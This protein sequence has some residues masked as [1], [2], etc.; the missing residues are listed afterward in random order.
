MISVLR[1]GH[2][3]FRDKRIT[4][5]VALVARAFTA[6]EIIVDTK[7]EVLENTIKSVYERFGNSFSIKTGVN[8]YNIVR[9]WKGTIVHLTMYGEELR[10]TISK[11]PRDA[12][13][14][15]IVGSEKVAPFFYEHADFNISIGKLFSYLKEP[16]SSSW[17]I[18]ICPF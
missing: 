14:L 10:K 6:D 16:F 17:C 18:V 2:R 15:I 3:P 11:I 7:D 5:H 8:P 1:L 9:N 4:T 13:I 12:D